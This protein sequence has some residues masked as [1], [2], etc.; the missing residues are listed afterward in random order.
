MKYIKETAKT[1]ASQMIEDDRF[2]ANNPLAA[3]NREAVELYKEEHKLSNDSA[4]KLFMAENMP[5]EFAT[6]IRK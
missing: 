3:E 6:M 2:Y 1:I 4:F 5:E